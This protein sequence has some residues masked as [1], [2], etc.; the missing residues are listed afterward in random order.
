MSEQPIRDLTQEQRIAKA[1]ATAKGPHILY[2]VNR[3]VMLYA[4]DCNFQTPFIPMTMKART[5]PGWEFEPPLIPEWHMDTI[6]VQEVGDINPVMPAKTDGMPT[7]YYDALCAE[8][9]REAI[10]RRVEQQKFR[11]F[12]SHHVRE[13]TLTVI[14]DDS[15]F[16]HAASNLHPIEIAKVEKE[17]AAA[18]ATLAKRLSGKSDEAVAHNRVATTS[19]AKSVKS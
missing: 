7:A 12:I 16:L 5:I 3:N 8:A 15:G 9:F 18:E 11:A 4:E 1:H 17:K 14:S 2:V 19:P 10:A 13:G 6:F